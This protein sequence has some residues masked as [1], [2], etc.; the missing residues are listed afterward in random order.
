M[1]VYAS[2]ITYNP[3]KELLGKA[4]SAVIDQIDKLI[5]VDNFSNNGFSFA[6]ISGRLSNEQ[7]DKTVF[8]GNDRNVGIAEALN[9]AVSVC[10]Q[11]GCEW[12]LTLDQDSV[13]PSDLIDSYRK[14][15]D[16]EKIGQLCCGFVDNNQT[17]LEV[18]K[19][20]PL[21]IPVSG[22]G[23]SGQYKVYACITSGSLL[24]VKA[25]LEVGGFNN[26]L[27]IDYVDYDISLKLY[28]KGFSNYY[29]PS[30]KMH[31]EFGD[32]HI[33]R[34]LWLRYTDY[35]FSP[36][37]VYYKARNAVYMKRK[38]PEFKAVFTKSLIYDL[39]CI[40]LGF[41]LKCLGQFI[42]GLMDSSSKICSYSSH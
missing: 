20:S 36:S 30:V 6:D 27:F 26:V 35:R 2:I 9:A 5:I 42:K 40:V 8:I 24:N 11:D 17:D 25:C 4:V 38:Y 13:V 41:R 34:F 15:L 21:T 1:T 18:E 3:K 14:Y 28:N 39:M 29:I 23:K 33:K 19:M 16:L 32:A 10:E 12:L 31:H 37:R 22:E 7:N